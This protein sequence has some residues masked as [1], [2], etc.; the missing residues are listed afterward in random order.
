MSD[1]KRVSHYNENLIKDNE[2]ALIKQKQA[3]KILIEHNTRITQL[4]G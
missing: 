2:Y 4:N 1:V 3:D